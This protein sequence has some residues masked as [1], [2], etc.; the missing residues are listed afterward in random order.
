M[1]KAV[2]YDAR[3]ESPTYRELS[4]IFMGDHQS[5]PAFDSAWCVPWMEMHFDGRISDNKCPNRAIQLSA[6][7]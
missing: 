7:G 5:D 6:T 1:I 2:L 3:P 4:E